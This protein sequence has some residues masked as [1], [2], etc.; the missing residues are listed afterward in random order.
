MSN[1]MLLNNETHTCSLR[2]QCLE[3]KVIWL[4]TMLLSQAELL[5]TAQIKRAL[6]P[7]NKKFLRNCWGQQLPNNPPLH[8]CVWCALLF[9]S[10]ES[11]GKRINSVISVTFSEPILSRGLVSL[12]DIPAADKETMCDRERESTLYLLPLSRVILLS[13]CFHSVVLARYK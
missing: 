10:D 11:I 5:I 12:Q 4:N 13:L 7:N 9:L 1:K 6:W 8:L 2:V 3:G